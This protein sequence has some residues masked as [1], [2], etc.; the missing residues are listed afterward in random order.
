MVEAST[1][2]ETKA[3]VAHLTLV[4]NE[5]TN[6]RAMADAGAKRL[7][8]AVAEFHEEGP[9]NQVKKRRKGRHLGAPQETVRLATDE[10]MADDAM[11]S[12]EHEIRQVDDAIAK[13]S[14]KSFVW[15][16]GRPR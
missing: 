13:A 6:E 4:P 2:H 16:V 1:K 8:A 11:R 12:V 5:S 9:P 14:D 3:I 10:A 7:L 15:R